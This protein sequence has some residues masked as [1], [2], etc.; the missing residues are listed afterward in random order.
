MR[1]PPAARFYM[2]RYTYQQ[3]SERRIRGFG[4]PRTLENFI[5]VRA[6]A[7]NH[8]SQKLYLVAHKVC[9]QTHCATL[10]EWLGLMA[11]GKSALFAYE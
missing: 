11:L 7:R 8:F 10:I 9:K 1:S 4:A 5:S 3:V 2:Y 6:Q